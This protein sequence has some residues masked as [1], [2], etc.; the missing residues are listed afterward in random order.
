[1][2]IN[3]IISVCRKELG[4]SQRE[5][6]RLSG[7]RAAA[8]SEFENGKKSLYSQS[9]EKICEVLEL[10]LK[11]AKPSKSSNAEN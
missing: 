3:S 2:K 1:M 11:P 7:V 10:E 9:L 8:I 4:I 5:L 6:S